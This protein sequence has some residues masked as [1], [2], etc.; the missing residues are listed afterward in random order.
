MTYHPRLSEGMAV[1]ARIKPAAKTADSEALS[2]EIDMKIHTRLMAIFNMG[3]YAGGNDGSVTVTFKAATSSGG[4]YSAV[5]GKALTTASFTGSAQD[6][7]VGIIEMTAEEL[8]ATLGATYR[9]VKLS[10]TSTN[11]NLTCGAVVLSGHSRYSWAEDNDL[12]AVTEI[13]S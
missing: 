8:V 2:D 9:Y 13:V 6:D 11:Q 3:D 7:A 4:T 5:T 10:V 12:S 1:V